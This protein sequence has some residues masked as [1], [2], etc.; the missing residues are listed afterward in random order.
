MTDLIAKLHAKGV[1]L[2]EEEG[3]LKVDTGEAILTEEEKE[4]ISN[5]EADI[6]SYLKEG[7]Q[8][9][10]P[11]SV[12]SLLTGLVSKGIRL[13]EENGQL[14]VQLGGAQI[15]A[16]EKQMIG[17]NKP[18]LLEYLSG[19]KIAYLSFAQERLWFLSELGLSAQYHLPGVLRVKGDFDIEAFKKTL[20]YIIDRHESFRTGFESIDG[21]A[22]QVV[23]QKYELPFKM[24]DI[25]DLEPEARDK[26]ANRLKSQISNEEFDM[27]RPPLLRAKIIKISSEEYILGLCMHHIISDGW[28]I[29]ILMGEISAVYGQLASGS[30]PYLPPLKLQYMDFTVWQHG[31]MA[32]K[33]YQDEIDYWKNQLS[34]IED[35]DLPTDFPRPSQPKG[36]GGF[37][38][39]RLDAET[40]A[41]LNRIATELKVSMF[42]LLASGVYI[43]LNKYS[44][45]TNFGL[46][47]PVA[48]RNNKEIE[49]LVGFFVN[50]LVVN[51]KRDNI[52][53]LTLKEVV[54]EI[55]QNIINGQDYQNL[56]FEKIV[57]ELSPERDLSR[58]PVFQVLVN[59]VNEENLGG[60]GGSGDKANGKKA[61]SMIPEDGN[62]RVAKFDLTF[63]LNIQR[64]DS[65]VLSLTYSKELYTEET[66]RQKLQYLSKILKSLAI[67]ADKKLADFG[68]LEKEQ[69]LALLAQGKRKAGH[70]IP[71]CLHKLFESHAEER[72]DSVGLILEESTL[73]Y[74][75]LNARANQMANFLQTRGVKAGELVAVSLNICEN[76]MVSLLAIMKVGAAYVPIDPMY[77]IERIKYI[78]QDSNARLLITSEE[79]DQAPGAAFEI[80]EKVFVDKDAVASQSTEFESFDDPYSRAYVIYTSGSTGNPKGVELTHANVNG[81][82]TNMVFVDV[83]PTDRILQA[84]NFAFDGSVIEIFS[85]LCNGA[86]LAMYEREEVFNTDR[87]ASFIM[88][89]EL[90]ITFMTTALLNAL[91]DEK[92]EVFENLR[93][94]SIGGERA[95]VS[96]MNRVLSVV[97]EG[98]LFNLYGPTETAVYSTFYPLENKTYSGNIPIGYP[99]ND[100]GLLVLDQNEKLVATGIPGELCITGGSVAKGYLGREEL[101]NSKFVENPYEPGVRMYKT[102][103]LV[104]WNN[105]GQ[106]EFLGRIDEQVK[107]RGYR[108]E[109]GEIESKIAE[110]D[111]IDNN[112]VVV[113]EVAG[114]RQL[115]AWFKGKGVNR[116][117]L[118]AFVGSKLPDYMVPSAF[119]EIDEMPLT[120]NGKVNRKLLASKKVELSGAG[121]YVAP[122]SV[123][124]VAIAEIWKEL[125]QVEKVG[126]HDTFFEL[127]GHSLLIT[128]LLSRINSQFQVNLS[129]RDIFNGPT[130]NEIVTNIEKS[131]HS[132]YVA[133]EKKERS[134]RIPLSFAQERLWF[135]NELGQGDQYH[136]PGVR[137]IGGKLDLPA[138][139]SALNKVVERHENLRTCFKKAD[140]QPYQYIYPELTIA[141]ERKE[142]S[143]VQPDDPKVT[144]LIA[145]FT[146]RPFDFENGPLLRAMLITLSEEQHVLSL[147][148][149]HVISDGWSMGV[150]TRELSALYEGYQKGLEVQLPELEVQYADY[151]IWQKETYTPEVLD[152]ELDHWEDH[153]KGYED[154]A[155]PTD[156]KRPR[157]LSGRGKTIAG[158]L[159]IEVAKELRQYCINT[160]STVFSGLMAGV[161]T[162]INIYSRQQDI[163]M[164]TPVANRNQKEIEPLIG[165]FVNTVVNRVQ[166]ADDDTF[167]SLQL[168]SKEEIFRS[169]QHQDI[170]FEKIV[171]R[172]QPVRDLS[173][174]PLFQLMLNYINVHGN[175]PGTAATGQSNSHQ[176]KA[177]YKY[178][179]FDLNFTFQEAT[180]GDIIYSLEYSEDLYAEET[181]RRM[182]SDMG[183]VF[184]KFVNNPNTP[185][186][187]IDLNLV[188][189]SKSDESA[190]PEKASAIKPVTQTLQ[191]KLDEVTT[192]VGERIAVRDEMHEISF[193][194][195]KE[196]SDRL[197][198]ILYQKGCRKDDLVAIS[199][200]RSVNMVIAVVAILKAGGAYF[201]IDPGYPSER[202]NQILKDSNARI[203]IS[204]SETVGAL[205][206]DFSGDLLLVDQEDFQREMKDVSGVLVSPMDPSGLSYVIYTSGSTGKPKGVLQTH[207]TIVNL[208]KYQNEEY[209][210]SLTEAKQVSQFASAS[211]DVSVQEIFYALLSGYT[212]NIVPEDVKYS[213]EKMLS[214]VQER[215]INIAYLPTAYL[216]YFCREYLQTKGISKFASLERIIVAGEALKMKT[217]IREFFT[218]NPQTK[219]E[220]QYGPSETHVVTAYTLTGQPDT[221]AELPSIGKPVANIEAY[222]L[223]DQ[224]K[225]V[226]VGA[227]G[228]LYF[229]GEGIARAYLN[230][231]SLTSE[232]FIPSPFSDG[233]LYRTGD[234]ARWGSDGNLQFLGRADTQVKVR[235]FRIELG[236]IETALNANSLVESSAVI[237]KEIDGS[238][239]LFAFVSLKNEEEQGKTESALKDHLR[240]LLPDYMIPSAIQQIDEIPL[241]IN[242]KVDRKQLAEKEIAFSSGTEYVAP[243]GEIEQSLSEMWKELLKLEKVGVSDNFFE[244]GG[245]SLLATQVVS[246]VNRK[247]Q[248]SVELKQLFNAPTIAELSKLIASEEQV[249]NQVALKKYDRPELIPLSFAQERLWY[250]NELGQGHQYHLPEITETRGEFQK[251]AFLKA[252]NFIVERHENLRTIFAESDGVAYQNIL[253]SIEVPLIHRDLKERDNKLDFANHLI[254]E[255]VN[256]SFDLKEGPLLRAMIIE[257]EPD[258]SI[259]GLCM[260]H[261]ISDGWSLKVLL[262]ELG[263]SYQAFAKNEQP[264]FA[265]LPVQY[266]D[267]A[268]WQKERY[269]DGALEKALDYWVEHL[270]GYEDLAMP[271]DFPRPRQISGKGKNVVKAF[272]PDL[273]SKLNEYSKTEGITTFSTLLTGVFALLNTYT[274]Q[275]DLCIGMPVANRTEEQLED[276]IGFFVNT[277]INRVQIDPKGTFSELQKNVNAELINSQNYQDVPFEKIVEAVK[278]ERDMSRTPIFQAMASYVK[279][280]DNLHENGVTNTESEANEQQG[281]L[282]LGYDIS[283]F[284]LNFVFTERTGKIYLS[285][286]YNT[287]LFKAETMDRL[288]SA[289]E[290]ILEAVV[291]TPEKK[292]SE[293]NLIGDQDADKIL[294]DFNK[295][296]AYEPSPLCLHE[297]FKEQAVANPEQIA[298]HFSNSSMT[299]EEL[300]ERSHQ[301]ALYLQALGVRKG[302]M[303]ALCLDRS[304]ETIITILAVLKAG[305]VYVP[306]DPAYPEERVKYILEDSGSKILLTTNH[307]LTKLKMIG[308]DEMIYVSVDTDQLLFDACQGVLTA[309]VTA[310][311]LAYIIYT[312]GSTG[313]PKGTTIRHKN[314]QRV[315]KYP[316]YIDITPEDRILQLSNYAFD[317]SV[318]DIFAALLNGASLVMISNHIMMN[319]SELSKYIAEKEVSISFMTTALFNSLAENSIET[320]NSLKTILFGGE[321]VSVN[322][323]NTA[324]KTLG[325]NKLIHVYGPTETT[326]FATYYPINKESYESNIPIG[327]PLTGTGLYVLNDSL[328]PVPIGLTGELYISGDGLAAG[329]LNREDLTYERFI[330][331]PFNENERLYKTG[332]LVKWD[333]EGQVVFEGRADQQVKV[334]GFRI[335]PGEIENVISGFKTVKRCAVIARDFKGTKQLVAFYTTDSEVVIDDLKNFIRA[336]LPEYMVPAAFVK[337]D[338]IPLTPNGKTN[339]KE[340]KKLDVKMESS[341]KYV[342]PETELQKK[343]VVIWQ[344]VLELE[345][346]GILD[347]F[348]ELGG[349]SLLATQIISRINHE[350]Q[351][352]VVLSKL[353]VEPNIKSLALLIEESGTE[354]GQSSND[355]FAGYEEDGQ[356]FI[357]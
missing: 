66:I 157:E 301:L 170:P 323:V 15:S 216:E 176:L 221:W 226:P 17:E 83:K 92:P 167:A 77:P 180:S 54:Q 36:I 13:A 104:K 292:I 69:E 34:E 51:I 311:D 198:L 250:I 152:K 203:L 275:D 252:I 353:L 315:C 46:G 132:D 98:K 33:K 121:T 47:L 59:S 24:I 120:S 20:A 23:H 211:F 166:I 289:L 127:G 117:E 297:L 236:E 248:V 30:N 18:T 291:E 151:A 299:Y 310:D 28:S 344:E 193:D 141:F 113:R 215:G 164:G 217:E 49:G 228:E 210:H 324:L 265:P 294:V 178:S 283:K 309:E 110:F 224:M 249:T 161:C 282:N 89:K 107:V 277:L 32:G 257:M 348:F 327:K 278:P 126:I 349:H 270:A 263:A 129:L 138:F 338:E 256:T 281:S 159:D 194:Q 91:I 75:E 354:E 322:H 225:P 90:T 177:D 7:P 21:T 288:M 67:N 150:L 62:Y 204:H 56:P 85:A 300:D 78:L 169:Q 116:T 298:I 219:L 174:T 212:L 227:V 153:L 128:Q 10:E 202:K 208:I 118:K 238:T 19:K 279:L 42:T 313:K 31:I 108:I 186:Q 335:E 196:L 8:K 63:D 4:Q 64:K 329:Y 133:L 44:R 100:T 253:P 183:T 331:S 86:A 302:E 199:M 35:I 16:E 245:H 147:C 27:S 168:K 134:G 158:R 314:V 330:K 262:K 95:S 172:V 82:V 190:T 242:G 189:D 273:S 26:E 306:I 61:Y 74:G 258:R 264:Q 197:A 55:H 185:I 50:T 287:D 220:N 162:L 119:M 347:N 188:P 142:F 237:T 173:R 181:I 296:T 305:G 274:R 251:E 135:L 101:T 336:R 284:E 84:A 68:L 351:V 38:S 346:V 79:L 72:P 240:S 87:I 200:D 40:S 139:E 276:L 58:T 268:L 206:D 192:A 321:Q 316:N 355:K 187:A 111:G 290:A 205:K 125:L 130:I 73:T 337:L 244:I 350:L 52:N 39:L 144:E 102:G 304:F 295:G 254:K 155:M 163:C 195:L 165:F 308:S 93:M 12:N 137:F 124:E 286:E 122:Q 148:M 271:L 325:K 45:Q 255:F 60:N 285:L 14:K 222:L 9:K 246:R 80:D 76:L 70:D 22:I 243:V 65:Y 106:I 260:H 267:Y 3:T 259:I 53:D 207:R 123:A 175:D 340:L 229:A 149:H 103:D 357:I 356:E 280:D 112:A 266:A 235:G 234:L 146:Q 214:F 339:T 352:E 293:V 307:L 230:N 71:K 233:N 318:F 143:G 145:E 88:E 171:E 156:F 201:S 5:Q 209:G 154:L 312:S 328:K 115:I 105:D 97:G 81:T 41:T 131:D 43:L 29:K 231:P 25:S 332:D 213:T 247:F 114:G 239:H 241:N 96:H 57:E 342:A 109:L 2:S 94:V 179:K 11:F 218:L 184:T 317:G 343:L 303:V 1:K 261:I 334:R 272:S 136:I 6:L 345:K 182:L 269:G 99:A 341:Q 326:V 320:L 140:D 333:E 160:G 232:K 48:N 319:V 191:A 223:N 37:E